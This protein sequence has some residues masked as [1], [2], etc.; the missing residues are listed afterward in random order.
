MRECTISLPA[1]HPKQQFA[2]ESAATEILLAGDTRAGKSYFVRRALILWCSLIPGLQCDIFRLN[3]DDVISENMTG[4]SSFPI[5]LTEWGKSGL[6]TIN[7]TEIIFWNESRI[8]LEHCSDDTVLDKHRGIAKHVRVFS[9]STQI[10]EHRIRALTG[11]VT[12]SDEMKARVPEYWKGRFPKILHVTNPK[13]ISLSYYR[14][15]FV[16]KRPPYTIEKVGAFLRQYIPA[17]LDDNPSEDKQTTIDRISEAYPDIQTQKA[18]INEDKTGITNWRAGIGEFFPEWDTSRHVIKD[19]VP[20][21]HWF[22]YRSG[23][24]GQGDPFAFYF[25]TISD[26]EVFRDHEGEE[27]WYPRG[28][29]IFY[30]EFY[31]CD[32]KDPSKGIHMPNKDIAYEII[33]RSELGFK[34]VPTLTDGKPFQATGGQTPA[35]DFEDAGVT[36]TQ[37]EMGPGSRV[38]GWTLM[39]RDLIGIP[40]NEY[41]SAGQPIRIPMVYFCECCHYAISYIPALPRHPNP[42]KRDDAAEHGEATHACD[43]VRYGIVAFSNVKDRKIVGEEKMKRDIAKIQNLKPTIKSIVSRTNG[44]MF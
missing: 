41:D 42:N 27:R 28:A 21:P 39:R 10:L 14:R 40:T 31:G 20:P 8:S 18:L 25:I 23:D 26:G 5:L 2:Y 1:F 44:S 32:S 17:F 29:R 15:E 19:F 13:G 22:R 34:K 4:E 7:K 9:E 36:L 35:K 33:A 3:W 38:S 30:N 16:E 6:A 43:A 24:T 11:W 37:V 12:M